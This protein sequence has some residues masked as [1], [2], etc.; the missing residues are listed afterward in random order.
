MQK[1]EF[2]L[3]LIFLE[4]KSFEFLSPSLRTLCIQNTVQ[5][6]INAYLS[7][8]GSCANVLI[9][10][11]LNNYP[12]VG[13][14]AFIYSKNCCKIMKNVKM[15]KLHIYNWIQIDTNGD[16][17]SRSEGNLVPITLFARRRRLTTITAE[18]FNLEATQ[19]MTTK[20][21]DLLIIIST[22]ANKA[23]SL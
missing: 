20:F 21:F 15:N 22:Q 11:G 12:D 10:K 4:N 23:G 19:F 1:P 17:L 8:E 5:L 3:I 6:L 13:V 14:R 7:F 2:I 16:M 18:V 9:G